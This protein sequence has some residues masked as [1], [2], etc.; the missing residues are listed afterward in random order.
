MTQQPRRR[1]LAFWTFSVGMLLVAIEVLARLASPT[2]QGLVGLQLVPTSEFVADHAARAEPLLSD[3]TTRTVLDSVVG[4]RYR[5][6]F[7]S[8][9]DRINQ[10]G[11]RS[12]REFT[13]VAPS[14]VRRV[15]AF[16]DSF[17][18]GSEVA[19]D[20]TWIAE[21]ERDTEDF[22]VL[23]YGVGGYGTDQAL[24]LYLRDGSEY[25]PEVVLIGFAP[26]NL[27]RAE[28]VYP[29]FIS[30]T[31][32]P[33]AKPR[34]T[35]DGDSLRLLP[36]PLSTRRDWERTISEPRRV[37][38]LGKHDVW[39]DRV[40]FENP[41]F[42]YSAA[43]R[44]GVTLGVRVWRKYLWSGR[45]LSGDEFRPAAAGFALQLKLLETFADSVRSRGALPVIVI[46]PDF[47]SMKR[48]LGAKPG[49]NARPVYAPLRDSLIARGRVEV[50]DLM[51]AFAAAG[52]D[53][54]LQGWFAPGLHYSPAGNAVVGRWVR[55]RLAALPVY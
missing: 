47:F 1:H 25:S 54:D 24:L 52:S 18:F 23:N 15:A 21:L 32:V 14:G 42:E 8:E 13:P 17:V 38:E 50:V 49:A 55:A 44:V 28:N 20:E 19:N 9:T 37:L 34:F 6:G 4:W 2:L 41:L 33:V 5:P 11:L 48:V 12:A 10:R 46:F 30:S 22:E 7:V 26:I 53:A 39:Y 31:D 35:L 40:Q 16:G 43:V 51:E 27:R 36:S 45:L 3:P 29:R